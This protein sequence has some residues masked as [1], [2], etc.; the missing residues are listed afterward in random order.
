MSNIA[1]EIII[2]LALI[3][4]NGFFS[5]SEMAIISARKSRLEQKAE[6]GSKGAVR[7]LALAE[8]PNRFLSTVQIGITTIGIL[9]GAFG[10]ATLAQEISKVIEKMP[11]LAPYSE[12]IGVGIV[13]VVITFFSLVVGELVPKR[14][15]LSNAEQVA[16]SISSF[17]Q[18]LSV[19]A[20][21]LVIL[22]STSTNLV[23]RLLGH[24]SSLE[25][26][27]TQDDLK[28]MLDQGTE[29]GVFEETEQDMVEH[30]LRLGDRTVSSLMTPRV[31]IVFLDLYADHDEIRHKITNHPFSRFPVFDGTPDNVVGIVQ[32][33]DILLQRVESP[34]FN[35]STVL[36][37]PLF[38]PESTGVLKVLEQFK[39]TGV[40]MAVVIDEYGGVLGLVSM[41][42]ILEAIVGDVTPA[43]G[44]RDAEA[45]RRE[46]GSWLF[47]GMIQIDKVKDF[48]DIDRLP[49]E[50]EGYYETLSGLM[51]T[52]LGKVPLT[53]D[54][55]EWEGFKF[56]VVDMDGR[57]VDKVMV[58][59]L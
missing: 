19:V 6:N 58:S 48:L 23:L 39:G 7:A 54:H 42:D 2:V 22:L 8:N 14:L 32:A 10:G 49:A 53:G 59:P 34:H 28:S 50:D 24:R 57:R 20:T 35:I 12:G 16:I 37:Q 18:K 26:E 40:E 27:V 13:V 38:I 55:F 4:L 17:M 21:P 1:T 46:D 43:Q 11:Q 5:M 44:E 9:S 36:Q 25:P 33:R 56:E 45:V 3:L 47:D 51:M 31:D 41:N 15:A 52:Q 30:I 29:A